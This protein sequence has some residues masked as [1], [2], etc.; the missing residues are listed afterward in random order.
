MQEFIN[1]IILVVIGVLIGYFALILEL[2]DPASALFCLLAACLVGMGLF[3][4]L[5]ES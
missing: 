1:S 3:R 5:L 4:L 2:P